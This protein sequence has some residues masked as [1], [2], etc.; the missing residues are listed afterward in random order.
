MTGAEPLVDDAIFDAIY[1]ADLVYVPDCWKLCGDAH[2]CSFSRH[3]AR[4]RIMAKSPF[5]ELPLLPGEYDYLR[6]RG[7][8]AQF[9][10]HEHRVTSFR[11]D[12]VEIRSE[13]ILSRRPGCACDHA[14]RPTICRLYPLLP[15]FDVSGVLQGA[16]RVSIYDDLEVIGGLPPACQLKSLP[17]AQLTPFLAITSALAR[18]PLLL[19]HLEAYRLTKRHV[20][21]RIGAGVRGSGGGSSDGSSG[22][23]VFRRFENDFLRRR[24]IDDAS[25]QED[26]GRLIR[27]FD[28]HHGD[29]RA[30]L[31]PAA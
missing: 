8:H 15:C 10:P 7:W 24:L 16:E 23:D 11:F 12:G 6:A 20:A 14:T 13:S 21:E 22:Q 28:A 27:A 9:D 25:L 17:F 2:C 4:F 19:F 30:G 31:I 26:L 5:Q 1:G 18:S 29:W 3:K